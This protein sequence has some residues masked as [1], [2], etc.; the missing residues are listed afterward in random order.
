MLL[1]GLHEIVAD[2]FGAGSETVTNMLRWVVFYMVNYP[3]VTRRGQMEIDEVARSEL[4]S[5]LDKPDII[6]TKT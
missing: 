4:E 3:D 5:I 2:L 6:R 1:T